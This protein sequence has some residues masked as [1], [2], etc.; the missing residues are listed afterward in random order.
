VPLGYSIMINLNVCLRSAHLGRIK[1][2]MSRLQGRAA[3][4]FRGGRPD[5]IDVISEREVAHAHFFPVVDGLH[6][7]QMH[8][9]EVVLFKLTF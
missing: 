4:S 6:L 2:R 3:L 9:A 5:L 8:I 7:A 1:F